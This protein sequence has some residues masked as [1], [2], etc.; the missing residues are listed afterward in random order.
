M[1]YLM[2]TA[3]WKLVA[4][5]KN[6]QVSFFVFFQ[7]VF[8]DELFWR[9]ASEQLSTNWLKTRFKKHGLYFIVPFG[10]FSKQRKRQI[11]CAS[12]KKRA[13]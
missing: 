2:K 13:K 6:S 8:F 11:L 4:R 9:I 1:M 10:E 12:T 3:Q 7:P 5:Y